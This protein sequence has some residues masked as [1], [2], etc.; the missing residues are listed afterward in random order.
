MLKPSYFREVDSQIVFKK[1]N[2]IN[3][4]EMLRDILKRIPDIGNVSTPPD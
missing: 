3:I 1:F 2:V 4:S